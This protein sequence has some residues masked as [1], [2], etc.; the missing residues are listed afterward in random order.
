MPRITSIAK[1][2][3]PYRLKQAQVRDYIARRF[4]NAGHKIDALM[5][6]FKNAQ[7]D[8]RYFSVPLDWFDRERSFQEKND[9][10]IESSCSLG[11]EASKACMEKAGVT[12]E[13][14]DNIIFISTTGLSTPSIDARLANLLKLRPHVKRIQVWG[15]GCVGGASAIAYA[16]DYLMAYPDE[17]VLVVAIELTG[18]TFQQNDYSKSNFVATALFGEGAAAVLLSG[19]EVDSGG[20]EILGTQST[21]WPDS[22]DVMGWNIN[23]EG[24]Q[25]ILSRRISAIVKKYIAENL[26]TFLENFA[27]ELNDVKYIIA[28]PGGAKVIDAYKEALNLSNGKIDKTAEVLR[29]YGNMSSVTVL[30][31]LDGYM[32]DGNI[33]PGDLGIITALG[34]GFSSESVLVRF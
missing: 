13:Q 1:A 28:H 8:E 18:L 31:V 17:R 12:P 22:L 9:K 2:L 10:Y 4:K 25:V 32:N 20:P 16:Y 34:P 19:D 3:P 6:V 29:K 21:I 23:S 14:I 27:L 30:F 15:L 7:I 11:V 26:S 24:M 33:K 5:P